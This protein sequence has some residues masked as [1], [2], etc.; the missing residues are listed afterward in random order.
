MLGRLYG[1]T[2][3]EQE[4]RRSH[5]PGSGVGLLDRPEP[6]STELAR[7]RDE[8]SARPA[9][10]NPPH[11]DA[12]PWRDASPFVFTGSGSEYFGIWIVN[13][14]LT[15]ATLG[16]YSPWAKVRR[17][18][19]FY[20]H[21]S[22]DGSCFEYL[23]DPRAILRGRLLAGALL[24]AY[25][26]LTR[27]GSV[28]A[29]A[30]LVGLGLLLPWLVHRSLRF[31][32][33]NSSYRGLRFRFTGSLG[34]AYQGFLLGPIL[35]IASLGT[36]VPALHWSIK[37]YQF[38]NARFGTA[39]F[40]C[41]PPLGAFYRAYVAAG[42]GTV[43]SL[44]AV[45]AGI[46]VLV[47]P[48]TEES[49][50]MVLANIVVLLFLLLLGRLARL[51]INARIQNAVWNHLGVGSRAF[52]STVSAG[53]LVAIDVA[54]LVAVVCTLGLFQP[55]AAVRLYKYRLECLTMGPGQELDQIAADPD[56]EIGAG[57]EETADAFDVDFG[58]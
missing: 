51:Y 58:F 47:G 43:L 22:L 21:T 7:T 32:L 44:L 50:E 5:D 3:P 40:K 14:A 25:V 23:G 15:V 39:E 55:F 46:G 36:L 56:Q 8:E 41:S 4:T 49:D 34:E 54:N 31:R 19:Y 11:S 20:G 16:F 38:Q 13:L 30:A 17:L 2:T 53:R 57:A 1:P 29:L 10:S 24:I 12:L 48:T 45:V 42:A 26:V 27:L 52:S 35:V 28:A 9:A 6:A 37:C 33:H 18:Q